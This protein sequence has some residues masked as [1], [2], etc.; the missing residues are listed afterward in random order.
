MA[1]YKFLTVD[2]L[3]EVLK[4]F[5]GDKIINVDWCDK[6]DIEETD[7]YVNIIP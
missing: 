3:I 1:E 6:F 5:D 4:D 7:D 2:E